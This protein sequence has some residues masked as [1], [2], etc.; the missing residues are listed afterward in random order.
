VTFTTAAPPER[1]LEYYRARATGAG[2][3]AEHQMRDGDHILA[4]TVGQSERAFYLILTP[5]RG[6]G[7]DV[8][9]ITSG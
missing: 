6:G 8:A 5:L 2:Y 4:G 1:V 9:M 7:S 3:S